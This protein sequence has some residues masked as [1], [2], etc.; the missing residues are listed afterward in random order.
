M[1]RAQGGADAAAAATVAPLLQLTRAA[2]KAETLSRFS[3]ALEL[4]ERA[5]AAAELA[6]PRDSL[7]IAALLAEQEATHYMA[8]CA[9]AS[10]LGCTA[11]C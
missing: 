6:L 9:N 3:R 1:Q 8:S 4:H 7:I 2:R 11:S 5:L 10:S